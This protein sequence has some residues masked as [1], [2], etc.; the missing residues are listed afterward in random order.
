M[1]CVCRYLPGNVWETLRGTGTHLE[2][3][4][5]GCAGVYWL[6]SGSIV[7]KGGDVGEL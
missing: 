2:D 3:C 6:K 5:V 1:F 7:A 4:R